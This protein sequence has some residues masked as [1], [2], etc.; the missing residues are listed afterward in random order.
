MASIGRQSKLSAE[1][2]RF[3]TSKAT[4]T[5]SPRPTVDLGYPTQAHGRIPAFH[6][7][8]EEAEFW[9]TH[10]FV[11]YLENFEPIDEVPE[12]SASLPVAVTLSSPERTLLERIARDKG[13]PPSSLIRMGIKERLE[14]ERKAS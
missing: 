11:D 14:Q 12:D 2:D 4:R 10:S 9:D 6:S 5:D 1:M 13:L 3:D 7:I 8:E